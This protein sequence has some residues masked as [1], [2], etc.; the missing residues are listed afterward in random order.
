MERIEDFK[1]TPI[2]D[3]ALKASPVTPWTPVPEPASWH[4]DVWQEPT[5]KRS[6]ATKLADLA[7]NGVS[8]VGGESR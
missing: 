5:G 8:I 3:A 1:E 2:Y 4:L 6:A 7:R